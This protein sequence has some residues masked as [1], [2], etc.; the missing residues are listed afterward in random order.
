MQPVIKRSATELLETGY[1]TV[2]RFV[3]MALTFVDTAG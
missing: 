2:F 1:I 3:N